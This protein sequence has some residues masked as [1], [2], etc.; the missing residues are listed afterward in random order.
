LRGWERPVLS[1]M[2]EYLIIEYKGGRVV[3]EYPYCCRFSFCKS[4]RIFG[5]SQP[6]SVTKVV[7][8][9]KHSLLSSGKS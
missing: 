3:T 1:G 7:P 5:A 6:S 9:P 4:A 2:D 8:T